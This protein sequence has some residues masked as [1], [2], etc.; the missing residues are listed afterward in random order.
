M[1][2]GDGRDEIF[3]RDGWRDSVDCGSGR[4]EV[5]ADRR[6]FVSRD[7]ERVFRSGRR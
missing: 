4:D 5:R 3:T 1:Y 6:D 7:C 2:G